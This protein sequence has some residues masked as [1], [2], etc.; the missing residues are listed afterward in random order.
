MMGGRAF[1]LLKAAL[2]RR[3]CPKR[4][5]AGLILLLKILG[6]WAAPSPKDRLPRGMANSTKVCR[7]CYPDHSRGAKV[8]AVSRKEK[9]VKAIDSIDE[10]IY[11]YKYLSALSDKD[12]YAANTRRAGAFTFH[13]SIRVEQMF[14]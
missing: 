8:G 7:F 1:I 13:F 2:G 10:K 6:D 3:E 14:E 5:E 11:T 9:Q 12:K 4:A